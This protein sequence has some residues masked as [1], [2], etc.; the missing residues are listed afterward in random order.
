MARLEA[1]PFNTPVTAIAGKGLK[2]S[3]YSLASIA[4]PAIITA[5]KTGTFDSKAVVFRIY[6][7]LNAPVLFKSV[8]HAIY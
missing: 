3:S 5:A 7:P 1:L 2:S 6:N 8:F 4:A